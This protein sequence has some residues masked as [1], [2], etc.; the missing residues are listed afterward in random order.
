MDS[1]KLNNKLVMHAS[2]AATQFEDKG[3]PGWWFSNDKDASQKRTRTALL[4]K[5]KV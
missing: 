4:E 2:Q 5:R 3:I 1:S